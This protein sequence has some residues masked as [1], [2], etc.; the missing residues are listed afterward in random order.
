MKKT[1]KA[2]RPARKTM[3]PFAAPR[4]RKL[5]NGVWKTDLG[6]KRPE[7]VILVLSNEEFRKFHA[8]TTAAKRYIDRRHFLK[9]KLIKVVFANHAK[10][11]DG[12]NWIVMISH[13]DYSTAAVLAYQV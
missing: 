12:G 9:R 5:P 6:G 7:V 13:T 11:G 4:W 2:R 10:N 3:Q 8:S 1:A